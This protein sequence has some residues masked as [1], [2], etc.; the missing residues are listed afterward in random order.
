MFFSIYIASI[1]LELVM[2]DGNNALYNILELIMYIHEDIAK[3]GTN[4]NFQ[5]HLKS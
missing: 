5:R 3:Y 2:K 1:F 4:T